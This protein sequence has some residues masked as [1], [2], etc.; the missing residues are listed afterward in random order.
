MEVR[1]QKEEVESDSLQIFGED[2]EQVGAKKIALDRQF[3][4]CCSTRKEAIAT[5]VSLAIP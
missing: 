3:L 1:I 5:A 2:V 4:F